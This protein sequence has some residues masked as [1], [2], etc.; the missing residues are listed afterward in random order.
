MKTVW[1]VLTV[2]GFHPEVKWMARA[3]RV[4]KIGAVSGN[5][6]IKINL[7]LHAFPVVTTKE[8]NVISIAFRHR[9]VHDGHNCRGTTGQWS[10]RHVLTLLNVTRFY[11]LRLMS[12]IQ[13]WSSRRLYASRGWS[14][15]FELMIICYSKVY[16]LPYN[17]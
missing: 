5:G 3:V 2:S 10:W 7:L 4:K 9:S 16:L 11:Q 12:Q 17:W 13:K 8:R 1:S 14:G 6:I 15:N